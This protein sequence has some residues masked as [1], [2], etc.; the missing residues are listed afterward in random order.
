MPLTAFAYLAAASVVCAILA[1]TRRNPVHSVLWVLALF[2][3]VGGVFL[4]AGAEFL[5][6]AQ[7]IIYAGA[8]LV[9]YLIVLTVLDWSEEQAG[10]RYGVHSALGIAAALG[11][12]GLA[13][14]AL[15]S[16]FAGGIL[17]AKA[18]HWRPSIAAIGAKLYGEYAV[19]FEA[20]SL[21]LLTAIVGAIVLAARKPLGRTLDPRGRPNGAPAAPAAPEARVQALQ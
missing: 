2:L 17:A 7:I 14:F 21:I 15:R 19:P 10:R 11:F 3:H 16:P 8:I 6:A 9:F 4:M 18:S 12:A 13:F 20:A 1:V 5:A